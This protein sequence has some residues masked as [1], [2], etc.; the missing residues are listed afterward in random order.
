MACAFGYSCPCSC[1]EVGAALRFLSTSDSARRDT[2]V[3]VFHPKFCKSAANESAE[4]RAEDNLYPAETPP[5]LTA[6]LAPWRRASCD[7]LDVRP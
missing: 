6:I 7:G 2:I 5:V 3:S 1:S 4:R